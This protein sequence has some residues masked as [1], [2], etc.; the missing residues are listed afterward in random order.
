M[1]LGTDCDAFL[2]FSTTCWTWPIQMNGTAPQMCGIH[3]VA[4][5]WCRV[6]RFK[7]GYEEVTSQLPVKCS[8]KKQLNTD[9][10]SNANVN[11]SYFFLTNF[12]LW[13]K[14]MGSKIVLFHQKKWHSEAARSN[15]R[16]YGKDIFGHTYKMKE[17]WE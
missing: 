6:L 1:G 12:T 4:A 7:T 14:S 8:L 2:F 13:R 17:T 9:H 3:T 10:S 15:S 5:K 11:D 16:K